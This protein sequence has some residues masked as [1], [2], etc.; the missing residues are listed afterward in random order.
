M[1]H[2]INNKTNNK[3]NKMSIKHTLY[4]VKKKQGIFL[5]LFSGIVGVF[6]SS[7]GF[8]QFDNDNPSY[9]DDTVEIIGEVNLSQHYFVLNDLYLKTYEKISETGGG[10]SVTAKDKGYY[11]VAQSLNVEKKDVELM[12][13]DTR[14]LNNGLK[15]QALQKFTEICS[16]DQSIEEKFVR[17]Q[18]YL[19]SRVR[20]E[21][22]RQQFQNDMHEYALMSQAFAN[23]TL[24]DTHGEFFDIIVDLN[25]I[26]LLLFGDKMNIPKTGSPFLSYYPFA[27]D[28]DSDSVNPIDDDNIDN[29]ENVIGAITD[30]EEV[31]TN[32]ATTSG[33]NP[34]SSTSIEGGDPF[35][36]LVGASE[37]NETLSSNRQN[38]FERQTDN[39]VIGSTTIEDGGFCVDPDGIVFR[40]ITTHTVIGDE[41]GDDDITFFTPYEISNF[42]NPDVYSSGNTVEEGNSM[43]N[44][45]G[46]DNNTAVSASYGAIANTVYPNNFSDIQRGNIINPEIKYRGGVYP[47]LSNIS[48]KN[49]CE[50][51]EDSFLR[52]RVCIK[53][54]CNEVLCIKINF[55]KGGK[56]RDTPLRKM[57]CVECHIDRANEALS[58]FI[59]TLGQNTPNQHPMESN[60]LSA[61]ENL[62]KNISTGIYL[63]PQRLPFLMY[64]QPHPNM[65]KEEQ[66][67]AEQEQADNQ[68]QTAD[69]TEDTTEAVETPE[70]EKNKFLYNALIV[71]NC[72][73]IS[74]NFRR[75]EGNA[76]DIA[77]YCNTVEKE[78]S[79]LAEAQKRL[80]EKK[81]IQNA[82]RSD[83]Y[84]KMLKPF[85]QQFT[86]DMVTVN[87]YIQSIDPANIKSKAK[88]CK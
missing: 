76:V 26:D 65:N 67:A 14:A 48:H 10:D 73:E 8:A 46:V 57:D 81:N 78:N 7:T 28:S 70:Y 50:D 60:F 66:E 59:G 53:K 84:D 13:L 80:N 34:A 33:T 22:E 52:G 69:T 18:L 27:P 77:E 54:I 87:N 11:A 9:E 43:L 47:D 12:L 6:C 44:Q 58:P 25:I 68:E 23:G 31:D 32:S 38:S 82:V 37:N 63:Y 72:S 51:D 3:A 24:Q 19:L 83:N 20:K 30:G 5:S 62:G 15:E 2:D 40:N 79:Y 36:E 64:D 45:Y 29:E 16:S 42:V 85:L 17:C 4:W 75:G 71:N 56:E 88:T 21:I 41:T 35:G 61:F 74:T 55:K 49:K 39:R 1:D 86:S